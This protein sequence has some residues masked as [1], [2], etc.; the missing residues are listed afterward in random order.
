MRSLFDKF[1]AFLNS[2]QGVIIALIFIYISG[3]LFTVLV[4]DANAYGPVHF[5]DEVRYWDIALSLY[6]GDFSFKNNL[7]YPPFYSISL[8]PAFHLFS[9]FTRYAAVKWLNALYITSAIFPAYLLLRKFTNRSTSILAVVI[10]LLNPIHL[11]LPRSI[12]SE[13][14]FYPIFMWAVLLAFT[15]LFPASHKARIPE[16]I[17]FGISLALLVATRFIALVLIP[18]L[19]LIWWLKPFEDEKP[20]FLISSKKL[21]HLF[22][23]LLPMV[24]V[25]GVWLLPGIAEGVPVKQ[26]LGFSIAGNSNPAQLGKRRLLMWIIFYLSYSVLIAAPYLSIL[27]AS[28]SQ[29]RLKNWQKDSN[30]WWLALGIIIFFFLLACVR[31]SWRAAYNFPDPTKLQGRY[32]LYFGPLFLITVFSFINKIG[33]SNHRFWFRLGLATLSGVLIL[34]AYA[35][36]FEGFVY[37]DGPLAISVSSPDGSLIRVMGRLFVILTLANVFFST[38]L[39]DKKKNIFLWVQVVFL[40]GFNIYGN[41]SIYQRTLSPRQLLNAQMDHLIQQI[42]TL[43]FSDQE[44]SQPIITIKVPAD[45]PSRVIRSWQQTLNFNGYTENEF[46]ENLSI[47]A[48][49]AIVFQASYAGHEFVLRELEMPEIPQSEGLVFSQSGYTYELLDQSV[50]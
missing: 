20:P 23:V 49:S 44:T 47:E 3:V 5:N 18:A 6:K 29:F 19:L 4:V 10:L 41:I 7:D 35:F 1:R 28:L 27:L 32:I 26:L 33:A 31:H 38:F 24:I 39:L 36:L 22:T 42:E 40:V 25:L 8:L 30:R 16:N 46:V 15:N 17:L 50:D 34:I 11:I 12:L 14:V 45:T 43:S 48:D 21:L 13:N 9:P 2:K 37:L